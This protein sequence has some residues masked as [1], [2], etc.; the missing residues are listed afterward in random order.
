MLKAI[1]VKIIKMKIL[2]KNIIS[3][4]YNG[5]KKR[6]KNTKIIK[7]KTVLDNRAYVLSALMEKLIVWP[8]VNI[9][10]ITNV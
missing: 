6:L 8:N 2:T 10:S 9:H 1:T 4:N 7:I 5:F 3:N